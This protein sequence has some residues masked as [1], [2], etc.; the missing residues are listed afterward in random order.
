MQFSMKK[1]PTWALAIP[2]ALTMPDDSSFGSMEHMLRE[3][4]TFLVY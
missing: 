3:M 2:H 4:V 1:I